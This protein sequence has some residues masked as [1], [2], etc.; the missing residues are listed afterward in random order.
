MA[1]VAARLIFWKAGPGADG[2]ETGK[3]L[4]A[5]VI[6]SNLVPIDGLSMLA[7]LKAVRG[8]ARLGIREQLFFLENARAEVSMEGD[9]HER[10]FDVRLYG[11]F[12]VLAKPLFQF[13]NQRGLLCFVQGDRELLK[14]WPT[15]KEFSVDKGYAARMQHV[16]ERHNQSLREQEPD[17]KRRAK[18]M[19]AYMRSDEFRNEMAREYTL[20]KN[21]HA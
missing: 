13:M 1:Q 17:P 5:G 19:T 11:N 12:E 21:T 4:C 7:Q 10:H 6:P 2:V 20:E 16:L 3:Q 9:I 8:F 18:M 14:E 15:F